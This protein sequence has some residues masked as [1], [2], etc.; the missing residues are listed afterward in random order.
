MYLLNHLYYV[1][2]KQKEI[3]NLND[4]RQHVLQRKFNAVAN[5]SVAVSFL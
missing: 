4:S 5:Y 1:E 2:V 3:N